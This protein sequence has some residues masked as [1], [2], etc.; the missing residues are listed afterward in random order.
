MLQAKRFIDAEDI[1]IEDVQETAKAL[2]EEAAASGIN[3]A[4]CAI[5]D[6]DK[7]VGKTLKVSV[8]WQRLKPGDLEWVT[9]DQQT[10]F[11][12][13]NSGRQT[14]ATPYASTSD[15]TALIH[16]RC[17][18]G[19]GKQHDMVAS[20]TAETELTPRSD[21]QQRREQLTRV[22]NAAAVQLAKEISCLEESK[23]PTSLGKLTAA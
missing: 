8:R 17:P 16:F 13:A 20:L 10:V 23:L 18:V 1:E 14:Y 7:T 4:I 22:A 9:R 6:S 21:Q 15:A 11:D 3:H 12:L 19:V 2:S 5:Q